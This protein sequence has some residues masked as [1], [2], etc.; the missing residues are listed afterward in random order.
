VTQL[1]DLLLS[2]IRLR[3]CAYL[4]GCEEADY[5]PVQQF[6][7]LTASN[8]SKQLSA[9]DN[10]GYVAITKVASGRYTTTRLRLTDIGTAALARHLDA[11]R[12]LA[13]E[14]STRSASL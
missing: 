10:R 11:L 1:D 5:Q 7:G 6:C 8:L 2:P 12:E 4:S 9:L 14:A 13:D 3:I